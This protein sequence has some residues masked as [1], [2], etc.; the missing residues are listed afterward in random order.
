MDGSALGLSSRYRRA[1][2]A[3]SASVSVAVMLVVTT[4]LVQEPHTDDPPS[5]LLDAVNF[6]LSLVP[7]TLQRLLDRQQRAPHGPRCCVGEGLAKICWPKPERPYSILSYQGEFGERGTGVA[8][9]DYADYFERL[10][11]G[12]SFIGGVLVGEDYALPKFQ[13]RF[14]DRVLLFSNSTWTLQSAVESFGI[15]TI[16]VLEA[17]LRTSL[18]HVEGAEILVHVVF[19]GLKKV[20]D[21][22]NKF[23]V[24]SP[25]VP[26]P[27]SMP[28][29]PHIVALV[30][31]ID[32]LRQ[33]LAIPA[34]AIVFCRHGGPTTFDIQ[35]A[36]E[37]VC[38]YA[39]R[40]LNNFVLLLN[41]D[42]SPCEAGLTNIVH[43]PAVTDLAH[44]ARF[45]ATCNACVHGRTLG[46]T[47]G[48]AIAECSLLGLPVYTFHKADPSSD[49]HLRVLGTHA[50]LYA[51][52]QDL[53]AAMEAFDLA[54]AEAQ[55]SVYMHLYD[56]FSPSAVMF[57]FLAN[58]GILERAMLGGGDDGR[59]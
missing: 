48:L 53:T 50:R 17:N 13:R 28:V 24:V 33:E 41:T 4:L 55:R 31:S 22:R 14:G 10:A 15:D 42:P 49:F 5:D 57:D 8:L 45:L 51:S 54:E 56:R 43:L 21:L 37:G 9:Y 36:R 26:H 19:D 18:P 1:Y 35:A 29:V 25:S 46:E 20:A 2:F 27:S 32:S 58:F 34:E 52:A 11:C 12:R 3:L 39:R 47:F 44:K 16:Y 59:R 6:K 7:H 30:P 38:E 23:A 40:H